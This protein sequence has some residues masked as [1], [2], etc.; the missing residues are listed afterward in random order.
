MPRYAD[1][2]RHVDARLFARA[3]RVCAQD[4][5]DAMLMMH[6]ILPFSDCPYFI[7]DDYLFL[8]PPMPKFDDKKEC[9]MREALPSI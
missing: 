8:M 1:P 4:G 7:F 2:A 6:I 9:D 3:M 5:D